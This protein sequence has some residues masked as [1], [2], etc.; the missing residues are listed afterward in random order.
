M[1]RPTYLPAAGLLALMAAPAL[2]QPED[3]QLLRLETG[4]AAVQTVQGLRS[5]AELARLVLQ[6]LPGGAAVL[7][8]QAP[9]GAA[10]GEAPGWRHPDGPA[11]ALEWQHCDAARC[12]ASARISAADLDRM[13]RGRALLIGYR[14]LP[15][16]RPLTLTVSLAGLTRSLAAAAACDG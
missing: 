10:L 6:P 12:T 3:W 15:D 13:R 9:N 8:L 11:M 5:G 7:L 1:V 2:A 16:S 4:C 14:P